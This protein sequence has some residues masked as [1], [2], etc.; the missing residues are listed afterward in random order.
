M[1]AHPGWQREGLTQVARTYELGTFARAIDLVVK[2]GALAEKH[3]HHPDL[4][5]R[6]ATVRVTWTTHDAGGLTRLDLAL[7]EASD[8]LVG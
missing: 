7:A 5:V 6:G 8:E 1:T 3:G 2:L 4:D